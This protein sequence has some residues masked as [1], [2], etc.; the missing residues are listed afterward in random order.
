MLGAKVEKGSCGGTLQYTGI[1]CA[2][3]L[4]CGAILERELVTLA[5]GGEKL[6]YGGVI[7]QCHLNVVEEEA[8][9]RV[10]VFV[11]EQR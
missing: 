10:I 5:G 6:Y 2:D 9:D 1:C 3:A 8:T 4:S 7:Q 11:S